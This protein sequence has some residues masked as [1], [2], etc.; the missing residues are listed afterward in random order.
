MIAS[1]CRPTHSKCLH[2]STRA[3]HFAVD[4][5]RETKIKKQAH[6]NV[7]FPGRSIVLSRL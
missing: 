7:L 1:S 4:K 5:A 6:K 2:V 3:E